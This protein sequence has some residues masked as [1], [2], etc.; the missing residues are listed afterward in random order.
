MK[1]NKVMPVPSKT[2]LASS[3]HSVLVNL[4]FLQ[5][6]GRVAEKEFETWIKN[7]HEN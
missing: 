7:E 1:L 4:Y 3:H 5:S 2:C 6:V